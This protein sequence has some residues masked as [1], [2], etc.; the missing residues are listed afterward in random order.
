MTAAWA[1]AVVTLA[2]ALVAGCSTSSGPTD[3]GPAC[4]IV[5]NPG[6]PVEMQVTALGADGTSSL[7]E[8]GGTVGL[9]FPPQGGRVIFAGVRATNLDPCEVQLTGVLKDPVNGELRLD[10]RTVNLAPTPDGTWA[11]S[12]DSDISSFANVPVCPNEWSSTDAYGHP[13]DLTVS[14]T[15]HEGR[16]ASETLG[17]VLACVEPARL[18]ECLCICKQGYVLGQSCPADGGAE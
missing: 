1:R 16:T 4:P 17:V 14:V 6:A 8:D 5:G 10:G 12:T 18:A 11:T 9:I 13:Y 2:A 7:V 15:D 3:A